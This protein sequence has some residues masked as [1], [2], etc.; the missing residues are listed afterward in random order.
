MAVDVAV[1]SLA[2]RCLGELPSHLAG[3]GG[4]SAVER[5]AE[6]L[7]TA[8]ADEAVKKGQLFLA[9]MWRGDDHVDV[10]CRAPELRPTPTNNNNGAA[11]QK[12]A[13]GLGAMMPAF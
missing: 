8:G 7:V 12:R 1:E 10:I 3:H 13:F 6:S 2:I 5:C 4:P 9:I 11:L